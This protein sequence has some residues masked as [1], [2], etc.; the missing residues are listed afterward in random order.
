MAGAGGVDGNGVCML[1][2]KCFRFVLF[3]FI[4]DVSVKGK[5]FGK[6]GGWSGGVFVA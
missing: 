6:K 5:Y 2:L 1:K 3:W 4:I